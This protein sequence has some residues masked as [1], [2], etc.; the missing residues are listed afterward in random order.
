MLLLF[1]FFFFFALTGAQFYDTTCEK[2]R[3]TKDQ[4]FDFDHTK[5]LAL[6]NHSCLVVFQTHN[7]DGSVASTTTLTAITNSYF[8]PAIGSIHSDSYTVGDPSGLIIRVDEYCA[9]DG[10]VCITLENAPPPLAG[11]YGESLDV[12]KGGKGTAWRTVSY[13]E[14]TAAKTLRGMQF[15]HP[16]P[17]GDILY[18]AVLDETG[19]LLFTTTQTCTFI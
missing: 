5:S 6:G 17:W 15:I 4:L 16:R 9:N 2:R 18:L 8:D 11:L 10:R 14:K 19:H 3:C 7:P 12:N 1:S 13:H